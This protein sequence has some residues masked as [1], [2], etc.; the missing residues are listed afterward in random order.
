MLFANYL[1]LGIN[2]FLRLSQL[3]L[4]FYKSIEENVHILHRLQ[5]YFKHNT[6]LIFRLFKAS[7]Y[8]KISRY[9]ITNQMFIATFNDDTS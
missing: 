4:S 1:E 3:F 6:V 9:K 7:L 2:L 8:V 5:Q